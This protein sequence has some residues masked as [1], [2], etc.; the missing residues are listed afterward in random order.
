MLR[1]TPKIKGVVW[2]PLFGVL[3]RSRRSPRSQADL[4]VEARKMEHGCPPTP[5]Q[6]KRDDQQKSPCTHV[7]S[8]WVI[9][10]GPPTAVKIQGK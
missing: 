8:V 10:L 2:R 9:R 5:R 4:A 3:W 6:R 7:P 1:C